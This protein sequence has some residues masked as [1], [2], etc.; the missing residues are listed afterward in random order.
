MAIDDYAHEQ[1]HGNRFARVLGTMNDIARFLNVE[2]HA[3][4][5]LD[6]LDQAAKDLLWGTWK[7]LAN[8]AVRVSNKIQKVLGFGPDEEPPPGSI[9]LEEHPPEDG[10][11]PVF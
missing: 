3:K 8:Q 10:S 6:W 9:I 2:A 11:I 4:K 5:A 1:M 7:F